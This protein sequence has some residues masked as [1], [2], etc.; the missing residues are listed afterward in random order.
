M[1]LMSIYTM[2]VIN[3]YILSTYI[4]Y[5]IVFAF[6]FNTGI[7]N[8]RPTN[9]QNYCMTVALILYKI[10]RYMFGK[11]ESE[12]LATYPKWVYFLLNPLM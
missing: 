5:T 8:V 9:I 3:V 12:I 1:A 2:N 11:N 10:R 4:W 7:S 6:F